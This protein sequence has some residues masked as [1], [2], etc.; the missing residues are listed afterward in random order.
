MRASRTPIIIRHIATGDE[1]HTTI[2]KAMGGYSPERLLRVHRKDPAL[3][4]VV[5]RVQR[6]SEERSYAR[7][8]GSIGIVQHS[9]WPDCIGGGELVW[10]SLGHHM[11]R[12]GF[13]VNVFSWAKATYGDGRLLPVAEIE[14]RN[15]EGMQ[16]HYVPNHRIISYIAA[17]AKRV[18]PVMLWT[19]MG[20][21]LGINMGL[22]TLT[23]LAPLIAYQQFWQ[24]VDTDKFSIPD[25]ATLMPEWG[26]VF[27]AP[28]HL[29]ANSEFTAER[30]GRIVG[31]EFDILI[32]PTEDA[33]GTS[34]LD[35]PV[36]MVGHSYEKGVDL[37]RR[38]ADH[39]PGNEFILI[40][41]KP[42][43]HADN[44]RSVGWADPRPYYQTAAALLA[45]SFVCETYG[46]AVEEARKWN[47]PTIVSDN[48][49]L[50]DHAEIALSTS[51]LD[52]W[53]TATGQAIRKTLRVTRP[54]LSKRDALRRF[55]GV[56]RRAGT[57]REGEPMRRRDFPTI[58]TYSGVKHTSV[59]YLNKALIDGFGLTDYPGGEI[60]EHVKHVM[61][62]SW[63]Q[64]QADLYATL[65]SHGRHPYA[66]LHSPMAQGQLDGEDDVFEQVLSLGTSHF[67]CGHAPM[68]QALGCRW[69]PVPILVGPIE[70]Q[71]R[72]PRPAG[73]TIRVG[74]WNTW[75]RRKNVWTQLL[76]CRE[77][78]R[79]SG[80]PVEL[81]AAINPD[82][83]HTVIGGSVMVFH[84]PFAAQRDYY[85]NM[86]SMDI[87]LQVTHAES[88]NYTA[89]ESYLLGAPCLVG[90]CTPAGRFGME[91]AF[92]VDDPTDPTLIA[93]MAWKAIQDAEHVW[94]HKRM[95]AGAMELVDY[96]HRA[97]HD[98]LEAIERGE[99]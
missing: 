62:H 87:N 19:T 56:I 28:H 76:A 55:E 63:A 86:G 88:F 45:P 59:A 32:P 13:D 96:R 14:E 95:I 30:L 44:C 66:V 49:A 41:D 47:I 74:M 94:W 92:V 3:Y 80:R 10:R 65:I 57:Q 17:W 4:R 21:D 26:G 2:P 15:V 84:T 60:P 8:T 81:H 70:E 50:R 48:G 69:L 27:D 43:I 71:R 23:S 24:G 1:T 85:V 61:L 46:M 83:L 68:A 40:G 82:G 22:A 52:G 12:L 6:V 90:P 78:S 37:F 98:T 93:Q 7:V 73:E 36:I 79:L 34:T 39:Y 25:N 89:M 29:V 31:R 9:A 77:L 11:Q 42:E 16:Y 91:S 67:L 33:L 35:G 58:A 64:G 72:G 75:S 53:V 20:F 38:V 51:D 5:G 18:H 54:T 99:I 97:L